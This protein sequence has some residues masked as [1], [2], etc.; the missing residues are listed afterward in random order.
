MMPKDEQ[1]LAIL[2]DRSGRNVA[3]KNVTVHAR[4]HGLMAEVEVEQTYKNSQAEN[5]EAIYMFPLPIGAVLL[6]LEVE[7]SGKK[8]SGTVVE[9]KAAERSYEDAI[10]DGDSAVMLQEAGPGLYAASIGNLMANESAVIRYR[11]GLML[12]WQSS[13]LRFLLPTA[14]APRYGDAIAAGLQP[15]QALESTLDVEYPFNLT[16]N[17]EGELAAAKIT[18]PSHSITVQPEGSGVSIRFAEKAVLD[19]DFI[20]NLESASAQ[21]SCIETQD[22]EGRVVAASLRIPPVQDTVEKPLSLKIVIDCSGSMAGTSIAQARKASLEILNLLRPKDRFNIT[23]FGSTCRHVFRKSV[24]ASAK[25]IT[26]AWN[27]LEGLEA[28]MGGTEMGNA[29][30]STF[31]LSAPDDQSSLLL[32]TDGEIHE[33]ENVIQ[34]AKAS[35]HRVFTVGV[36]NAVS[37]AFLKSLSRETGGACELAAPQE[38]V[39]EKILN[40]FHRFRQPQIEELHIV[41]PSAP[42]WTTA[43]PVA[44][45]AGDT[46]H[47]FAGFDK[48]LAGQLVLHASAGGE[49]FDISSPIVPSEELELPRIAAAKRVETATETQGLQLSLAYQLLSRWTSYLVIAERETKANDLPVLHQ[50]PQMLAAGWGGIGQTPSALQRA[51]SKNKVLKSCNFEDFDDDVEPDLPPEHDQLSADSTELNLLATSESE[52]RHLTPQEFIARMEAG[53]GKFGSFSDLPSTIRA[54]RDCGISSCWAVFLLFTKNRGHDEE[55]VITAFLYALSESPIG[56]RF[57]RSFKRLVLKKWKDSGRDEQLSNLM[58]SQLVTIDT[59]NWNIPDYK[60]IDRVDS[61]KLIAEIEAPKELI[62][63]VSD[64]RNIEGTVKTLVRASWAD[65]QLSRLDLLLRNHRIIR[66]TFFLVLVIWPIFTDLLELDSYAWAKITFIRPWDAFTPKALLSTSLFILT[67]L[68]V[69]T[70]FFDKNIMN[71]LKN[72]DLVES[73]LLQAIVFSLYQF[74]GFILIAQWFDFLRNWGATNNT[75]YALFLLIN[76]LSWCVIKMIKNDN[77]PIFSWK[78]KNINRLIILAVLFALGFIYTRPDTYSNHYDSVQSS[79]QSYLVERNTI[80]FN[81]VIEEIDQAKEDGVMFNNTFLLRMIG[82]IVQFDCRVVA[83]QKFNEI[84]DN[85]VPI[86]PNLDPIPLPST[87]SECESQVQNAYFKQVS[88]VL[89]RLSIFLCNSNRIS[90]N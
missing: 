83:F 13:K 20:L 34:L 72:T 64:S 19:R 75:L 25:N 57:G 51:N 84:S 59:E 86:I 65:R 66:Y 17:I 10:T 30:K 18:S 73:P 41:W 81:S 90:C 78:V 53:V 42:V 31:A 89:Q 1:S 54:I 26:K 74:V 60:M 88:Q 11:Y 33:H 56:D 80:A 55:K 40:Q 6:G 63:S 32:I 4:I 68:I 46:V 44:A 79:V 15:H 67:T 71:R 28:D 35:Q 87:R 49:T 70:I 50:V 45:F 61:S 23:L 24:L 9:R 22:G 43:L 21:S 62:E 52:N 14:I 39:C 5:I 37:E 38:G 36:G 3:L 12:S 47:V 58:L 85:H 16:I 77:N 27:H 82:N 2:R 7:F 8:L 69:V 29:L 48:P 76:V